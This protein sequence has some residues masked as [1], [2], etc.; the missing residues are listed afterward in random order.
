[1][2]PPLPK[3]ALMLFLT[4]AVANI[5]VVAFHQPI[6]N[7]G[8]ASRPSALHATD[9][10]QISRRGIFS[11]AASTTFTAAS[12]AAIFGGGLPFSSPNPANAIGP[13]KINLLNPKY[14]AVACPRDKPIPGNK[15]EL[16]WLRG[17]TGRRQ[18]I[19]Q[20]G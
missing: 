3:T 10:N 11:K 2:Q 7:H 13:V 20:S 9:N 8:R 16:I 5:A 12:I 6:A 17:D 19:G 1:M 14:S 15:G 4:A 18:V